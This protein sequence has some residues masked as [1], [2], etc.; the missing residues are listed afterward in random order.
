MEP[1]LKMVFLDH[2]TPFGTQR[3]R[4][5]ALVKKN[6]VLCSFWLVV[7]VKGEN[8]SCFQAVKCNGHQAGWWHTWNNG[9]VSRFF[10]VVCLM[11]ICRYGYVKGLCHQDVAVL[12]LIC[13]EVIYP[14]T[15]CSCRVIK[16]I[17]TKFHQ[18]ALGRNTRQFCSKSVM[19]EYFIHRLLRENTWWAQ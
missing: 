16:R 3:V 9:S 5:L 11:N 12:G 15:K 1:K 14:N 10:F 4:R 8:L 19:V 17:S 13:P 7:V 6:A 2:F 18:G